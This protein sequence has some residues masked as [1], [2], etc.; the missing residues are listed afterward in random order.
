[1]KF[2]FLL[3]SIIIEIKR[4]E[5]REGKGGKEKGR[6]RRRE[7]RRREEK[8]REKEREKNG[9]REGYEYR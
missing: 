4:C 6:E 1:M 3:G 7:R 9:E 5:E 2:V 8:R